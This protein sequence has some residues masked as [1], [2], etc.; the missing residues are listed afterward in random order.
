MATAPERI[1]DSRG[2]RSPAA[3][4]WAACGSQPPPM[5]P[6]AIRLARALGTMPLWSLLPSLPLLPLAGLLLARD[7]RRAGIRA[8]RQAR[9]AADRIFAVEH[10]RLP[11]HQLAGV[12]RRELRSAA[13]QLPRQ[14][15]AFLDSLALAAIA[16]QRVLGLRPHL[17]QLAAAVSVLLGRAGERG[18]GEG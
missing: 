8:M 18:C 13:H 17:A 6:M 16:A 15:A 12:A 3:P 2:T 1:G 4:A 5:S 7:D 9:V 10:C 11:L 14:A